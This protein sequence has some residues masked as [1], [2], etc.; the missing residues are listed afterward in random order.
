MGGEEGALSRA[1]L[2]KPVKPV[3]QSW[4]GWGPGRG[5]ESAAPGWGNAGEEAVWGLLP[6][7]SPG[8]PAL[9]PALHPPLPPK[10]LFLW[11]GQV[12]PQPGGMESPCPTLEQAGLFLAAPSQST[13]CHLGLR[14]RLFHQPPAGGHQ[15]GRTVW[16]HPQS[17]PG[18]PGPLCGSEECAGWGA[19]RLA[20]LGLLW[21]VRVSGWCDWDAAAGPVGW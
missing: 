16:S 21:P 15:A 13:K 9:G 20:G 11:A 7:G 18:K 14:P 17:T 8:T 10:P 2:G 6:T 5:C 12:D 19:P 3:W 4:L 1:V